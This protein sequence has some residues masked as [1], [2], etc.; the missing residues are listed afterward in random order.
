MKKLKLVLLVV[1]LFVL[2]GSLWVS[3]NYY[4]NDLGTFNANFTDSYIVDVSVIT[5][6]YNPGG[7]FTSVRAST[8]MHVPRNSGYDVQGMARTILVAVNG[9]TKEAFNNDYKTNVYEINCGKVTI[10]GQNYA[11][12]IDH[13]G[14]YRELSGSTIVNTY[15]YVNYAR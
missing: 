14:S 13:I 5:R 3:A 9:T 15:T 1:F 6:R 4:F 10:S 7:L 12:A 2:F 11:K 8:D